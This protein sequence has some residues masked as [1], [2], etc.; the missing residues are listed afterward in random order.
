MACIHAEMRTIGPRFHDSRLVMPL[1]NDGITWPRSGNVSAPYDD[2]IVLWYT[3]DNAE[4]SLNNG[5]GV[6]PGSPVDFDAA[7]PIGTGAN[8]ADYEPDGATRVL[9]TGLISASIQVR[10]QQV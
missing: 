7:P 8:D 3:R 6:S 9:A 4:G 10:I 1:T 5:L 2:T